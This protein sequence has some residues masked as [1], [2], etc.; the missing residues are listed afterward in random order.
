MYAKKGCFLS[1]GYFKLPMDISKQACREDVMKQNI[2]KLRWLH[3]NGLKR[4]F[5]ETKLFKSNTFS[6]IM[7]FITPAKASWNGMNSSCWRSDALRI[8]GFNTQMRYGG[9]DREFG[10][11][12]MNAGI[13]SRQLRY[14]LVCVHLDHSRPYKNEEAI[15]KNKQIRKETK[16]KRLIETPCGIR[17]SK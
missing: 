11:R 8:N 3:Q 17:Q 6:V 10:E 1:G 9:E 13:K 5:K 7:N 15:A 4:T 14:S 2:F 16:E 12:L